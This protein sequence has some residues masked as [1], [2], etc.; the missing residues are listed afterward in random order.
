MVASLRVWR[1][2][3]GVHVPRSAFA[4]LCDVNTLAIGPADRGCTVNMTGS[5][6][7][8]SWDALID[9]TGTRVVERTVHSGEFPEY[10]YETTQ[11]VSKFPPGM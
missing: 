3:E 2:K 4:D 10:A 1:G 7:G 11:Y 5:D 8:G 6:A 9:V